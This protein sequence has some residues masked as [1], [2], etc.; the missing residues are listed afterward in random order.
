MPVW[1]F[2]LFFTLVTSRSH[3]YGHEMDYLDITPEEWE[4]CVIDSGAYLG[5]VTQ[6]LDV[7][8]EFVRQSGIHVAH[9]VLEQMCERRVARVREIVTRVEP[10]ILETLRELRRR[11]HRLCLISNAD[12]IDAL[13]WRDSPL[14]PLFG[15]A[16]FSCDVHMVKP[17]PAIY[18]LA[19]QKMAAAPEDCIFVGDGGSDELMGAKRAGMRTI[20]ARHFVQLEVAGADWVAERFGDL[21]SHPLCPSGISPKG[22]TGK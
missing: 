3:V 13:H 7:V 22:A 14:A 20:Q 10:E 11:G 2:D 4:R 8:R 16:I 1:C 17:D 6:P 5:R 21:L 9:S 18:L 12:A 15:E 19:A